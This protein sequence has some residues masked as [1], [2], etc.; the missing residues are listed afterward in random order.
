MT[1]WLALWTSVRTASS[2]QFLLAE[3]ELPAA[4]FVVRVSVRPPT[5]TVVEALTTVVPAVDE[6]RLTVQLPVAPTV[7]HELALSEPGPDA[8][9]K[10]IVVPAGALV[11]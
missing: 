5:E 1:S 2:A 7:V 3:L 6:T 11:K 9:A 4:L 10:L 8:I